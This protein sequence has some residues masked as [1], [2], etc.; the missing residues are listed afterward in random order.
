VVQ[1]LMADGSVHSIAV[2][3]DDTVLEAL[4]TKSGGEIVGDF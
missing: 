2:D 3:V 1:F 4:A